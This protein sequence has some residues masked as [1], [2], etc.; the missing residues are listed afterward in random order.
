MT[1]QEMIEQAFLQLVF[2]IKLLTYTELGKIDKAEFD[3]DVLIKLSKRNLPFPAGTFRSDDDI[4]LAAQNNFCIT[5]GFTAIVLDEALNRAGSVRELD[6]ASPH[7]D[8]RT[9]VYMVRCA[10][11]HDMM[12]PRWEARGPFARQLCV[13]LPSGPL[14]V[15]TAALNGRAFDHAAIGGMETYFEIRNEVERL[16]IEA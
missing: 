8:L 1:T 12:N 4:V 15:D 3:G 11:A 9:L 7:R 16:T 13:L 5:L 14:R 2:A 10:F 6:E